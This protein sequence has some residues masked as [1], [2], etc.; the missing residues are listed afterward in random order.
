M[1]LEKIAAQKKFQ[2]SEESGH[3]EDFILPEVEVNDMQ[4]NQGSSTPD[5]GNQ[6]RNNSGLGVQVGTNRTS[7]LETPTPVAHTENKDSNSELSPQN[8]KLELHTVKFN[9]TTLWTGKLNG[10]KIDGLNSRV[11][12]IAEQIHCM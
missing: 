7:S 4:A 1:Y 10:L 8:S 6:S 11:V 2:E 3:G 5:S 12:W 9:K